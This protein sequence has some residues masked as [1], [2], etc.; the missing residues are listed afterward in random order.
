MPLKDYDKKRDFGST[1]E[2]GS[3]K[4][5]SRTKKGES[6]VFV[7]Q[8]HYAS[9]LHYDF[10]LELEGVLKSW[11]V[12]KGPTLDPGN[13]HLAVLVEDHP[14]DYKDFSGIIPEGNYGAGKVE[15]WDNGTYHSLNAEDKDGSE[16]EVKAGL[17]KGHITIIME[18]NRLNGEFALIKLKNSRGNNWLL[19][20]KNDEYA[21]RGWKIDTDASPDDVKKN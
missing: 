1:S 6:L 13:K 12:P 15:I 14:Y 2:P 20:K 3:G 21:E 7:V 9:H 11:A 17:E 16:E 5:P 18:G 8:K 4:K 10:R 19:I